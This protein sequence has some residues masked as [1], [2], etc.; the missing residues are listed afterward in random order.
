MLKGVENSR[1]ETPII[2]E[3][4]VIIKEVKVQSTGRQLIVQLPV[5]IQEALE[6][7]K[8][9]TFVFT[10]S[11]KNPKEYSIKIKRRK[12]NGKERTRSD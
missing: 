11:M 1:F 9:D 5:A 7:N 4:E 12:Q 10:V 2:T 8:G 3:P 6:I